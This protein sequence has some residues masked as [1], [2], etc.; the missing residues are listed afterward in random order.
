MLLISHL[1]HLFGLVCLIDNEFLGFLKQFLS[2]KGHKNEGPS[3]NLLS[4]RKWYS[5]ITLVNFA[6][7]KW[8]S[9]P[10]FHLLPFLFL[11][12]YSSLLV[13]VL[14]WS[15]GNSNMKWASEL[16]MIFGKYYNLRCKG[17]T[18]SGISFIVLISHVTMEATLLV[19][20]YSGKS[21]YIDL[22]LAIIIIIIIKVLH[23]SY[24]VD[25]V[26]SVSFT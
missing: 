2:I 25:F 3:N 18:S 16:F 20:W 11:H 22:I 1:S 15:L 14:I 6:I 17:D 24:E 4:V 13:P 23:H 8:C 21:Y 26:N 5:P 10:Y 9:H 7:G 19:G 12:A